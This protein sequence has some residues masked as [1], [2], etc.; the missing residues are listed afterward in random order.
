MTKRKL[1]S[2]SKL[3]EE[4]EHLVLAG[5]IDPDV[6]RQCV[7]PMAANQ[8]RILLVKDYH[9]TVPKDRLSEMQESLSQAAQAGQ[10]PHPFKPEQG[11]KEVVLV[12]WGL[13]LFGNRG[14]RALT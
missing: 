14:D 11:L 13:D 9:F 1:L 7:P 12:V 5:P 8:D 3:L 10:S 4:V 2:L 6:Q